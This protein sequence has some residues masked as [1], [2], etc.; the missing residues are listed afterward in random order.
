MSE[1]SIVSLVVLEMGRVEAA[2]SAGRVFGP[3]TG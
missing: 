1:H 2:E 3:N